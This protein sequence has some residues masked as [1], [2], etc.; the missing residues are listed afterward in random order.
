V[1]AEYSSRDYIFFLWKVPMQTWQTDSFF[2]KK[3][4]TYL[5]ALWYVDKLKFYSLGLTITKFSIFPLSASAICHL[6]SKFLTKI[7]KKNLIWLRL[8]T[9]F[10]KKWTIDMQKKKTHDQ[11]PTPYFQAKIQYTWTKRWYTDLWF[12]MPTWSD[13]CWKKKSRPRSI[14]SRSKNPTH[15]KH[16]ISMQRN[17]VKLAIILLPFFIW[18]EI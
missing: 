1:T 5:A 7:N 6:Y 3:K 14:C 10:T 11:K 2:W 9:T 17:W 8:D 12:Y 4:L 13:Y 16:I 18:T 15:P